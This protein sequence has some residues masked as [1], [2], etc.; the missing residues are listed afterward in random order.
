ME[1]STDRKANT[2]RRVV[3]VLFCL[4]AIASLG[5]IYFVGD[6]AGV[7]EKIAAAESQA[8]LRDITDPEQLDEALR[9]HPS[10]KTL[11]LIALADKASIA[12]DAATR[13]LLDEAEPAT[14]SRGL[15]L[16]T[17]NR[18]DL[19]A[20]QRTL[21]TA[22][23][24]ATTFMPR[25]T[26]LIRNAR[27]EVEKDARSLN[28][29]DNTVARF[30]AVID[31]QNKEMTTSTSNLLAAHVEFYRASGKCVAL[32]LREFGIYKVS[33]GQFV[34]PLQTTANRYNL[35]A[36]AMATT[37][38]RITELEEERRT[39]IRSRLNRWKQ[40]ADGR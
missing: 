34:F 23:D 12:T 21:K 9:Q 37:A 40:F 8:I 39:S 24:N 13:R 26:V 15:N 6:L 29:A 14:L 36:A 19:E 4:L 17:A 5:V 20:L 11:K 32:L 7:Q 28:A 31:E 25:Y 22:E 2:S 33:N 30:I 3:L 27:D 35:M 38:R 10:N 18:A 16:G 1:T